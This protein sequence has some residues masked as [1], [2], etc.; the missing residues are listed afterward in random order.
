LP[1]KR[2]VQHK[3]YSIDGLSKEQQN[4]FQNYV[5]DPYTQ[6]ECVFCHTEIPWCEMQAN[7]PKDEEDGL[8]SWCRH[9]EEKDD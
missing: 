2:Q 7:I 3:R 6:K 9:R 4:V 1:E 5:L 8:C